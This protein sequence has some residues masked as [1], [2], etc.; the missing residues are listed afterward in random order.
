MPSSFARLGLMLSGRYLGLFL[1]HPFRTNYLLKCSRHGSEQPQGSRQSPGRGCWQGLSS[2]CMDE[3]P[4]HLCSR[5]SPQEAVSPPVQVNLMT[6]QSVCVYRNTCVPAHHT[7]T[8]HRVCLWLLTVSRRFVSL[9]V[10]GMDSWVLYLLGLR[11]PLCLLRKEG[12]GG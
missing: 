4:P 10:L 5:P 11:L 3:F 6:R 9:M 12:R 1:Q 8:H 2:S 7:H